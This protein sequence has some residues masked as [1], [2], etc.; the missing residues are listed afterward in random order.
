MVLLVAVFPFLFSA[1]RNKKRFAL[2]IWLPN[3]HGCVLHFVWLA[4]KRYLAQVKDA[5]LIFFPAVNAD[6]KQV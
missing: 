1:V 5:Q 3:F 4:Y 2:V 6:K